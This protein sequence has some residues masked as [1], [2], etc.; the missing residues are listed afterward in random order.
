MHTDYDEIAEDYKKSKE[1]PW[2][3]HVEQ[4]S[5][6]K[7][8][9]DVAGKSVLDLACG[10]GHY[11]RRVKQRGAGRMVGVDIS[12]GM[13][14]LA[15]KQEAARPLG[16]EYVTEDAKKLSLPEKFD[17]V[18]ASYLIN[19]AENEAEL[20]AM[21]AGIARHLKPGGRFVTVN[22]NPGQPVATY[23]SERPYG[24]I[25]ELKGGK[26]VPGAPVVYTCF[27]EGNQ[28]VT[29]ENYYLSETTHE[30]VFKAAGFTNVRWHPV[31]LAPEG[32]RDQGR[33]FWQA[34]LDAQPIICLE[35]TKV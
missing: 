29:F 31:T 23:G 28:T 33:A 34:F 1:A 22:N 5:L 35:A 12:Q 14:D 16:I 27:L 10:E 13:I 19:Y 11:T 9:G 24:F 6:F 25:K 21:A 3:L 30:Q 2:R 4:H 17:L 20:A 8:M 32:E 26:Q 18:I 15:L 7:L